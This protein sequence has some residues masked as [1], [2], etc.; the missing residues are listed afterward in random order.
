M[1]TSCACVGL[2]LSLLLANSHT[3]P[4][5]RAREA[6]SPAASHRPNHFAPPPFRG[7]DAAK[8]HNLS[9][10]SPKYRFGRALVGLG[11]TAEN[12]RRVADS[13]GLAYLGENRV[14]FAD[15]TVVDCISGFGGP[16][17]AWQYQP[18]H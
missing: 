2:T 3:T 8:W 16:R 5:L 12:L 7:Y 14:R 15:G 17:A 10:Q 18:I 6:Q 11:P 1:N 9:V 4:Q 13:Q